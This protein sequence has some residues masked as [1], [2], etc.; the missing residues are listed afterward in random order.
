MATLVEVIVEGARIGL[1]LGDAQLLARYQRW[2]GLD[3]LS[4]AW[5]TDT[6]TRL[7]G[8]PGRTASAVRRIGLGG[9]QRM[10]WLKHFFMNEARGEN[11]DLP[12]LLQGALV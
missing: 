5:S 12:R 9:V 11:G 4:V 10:G 3:N 6:L 2:R 7:F 1:D 8:V